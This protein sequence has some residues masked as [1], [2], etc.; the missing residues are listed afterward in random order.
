[1]PV[2]NGSVINTSQYEINHTSFSK[3]Q[4][5]NVSVVSEDNETSYYAVIAACSQYNN[6]RKNIP[7]KPFPPVPD[8][9]LKALYSSLLTYPNWKE[10]NIILLLNEEATREN[11]I[12]AFENMSQRVT[13]ND[14]FL[15]Q[16]Q[17]HGSEIIDDNNDELDGTDEIIC[18][19]DIDGNKT[20]V[21]SDDDLN[22]YFSQINAKGQIIIIESC[23]SGGLVNGENDIDQGDRVIILST[24]PNAIGRGT[25]LF[26]F[27][28]NFGIAA[29][30]NQELNISAKDKNG[31]GFISIQ[32]CFNRAKYIILGENSVYWGIAGSWIL[33]N[34][35]N[36]Q[37]SL[38]GM[39][40]YSLF[41]EFLSIFI[42]SHPI[43]N[44]PHLIDNYGNEIPFVVL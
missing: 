17:G 21:L 6:S 19:Y 37:D 3:K 12:L 14:I 26:G 24:L 28:M 43:A 5:G 29:S 25:F 11:I 18:P 32:E 22:Y 4:E 36:L 39:I 10:E 8:H 33:L 34:L 31:D 40:L 44:Y 7:K 23:L 42:T 13:S 16:W 1:M 27:P 20:V 9:K 15:F 38:K 30:L 41:M 2:F 35:K